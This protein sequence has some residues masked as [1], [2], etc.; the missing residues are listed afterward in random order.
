[1]HSKNI[2]LQNIITT[3]PA[4]GLALMMTDFVSHIYVKPGIGWVDIW[5]QVW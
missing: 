2:I 1:M 3:F 5:D 4:E